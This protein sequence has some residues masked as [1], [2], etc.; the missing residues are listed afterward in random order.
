METY[1]LAHHGVTG[2]KWGVMHG[3]PYPLARTSDGRLNT[4]A[5]A[6]AKRRYG[7]IQQVTVADIKKQEKKM[8]LRTLLEERRKKKK[9]ERAAREAIREK[10]AA[11]RKAE[12]EA[13]EAA[14]R[15]MADEKLKKA[16][17]DK[18]A[19]LKQY[20]RNHPR[21]LAKYTD[22]FTNEELEEIVSQ[23]R[24][25]RKVKDVRDEEYRRYQRYADDA[26]SALKTVSAMAE[27]SI[28]IYNSTASIWNAIGK[29]KYDRKIFERD[30]AEAKKAKD[31]VEPFR[32]L[33]RVGGNN[34]Q[35]GDK[36]KQNQ[37]NNNNQ[38]NQN[39]Q[40]QNNQGDQQKK[41]KK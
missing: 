32:P 19:A 23:I 8:A 33:P 6:K 15:K 20:V 18:Q 25:D 17:Q 9:D 3:P 35:N 22:L 40:N 2:M 21:E 24:L 29:E 37:Q 39:N 38:N 16:E 10:E 11:E 5:Q 1:Y 14:R 12:R 27:T 41:K 7:T 26:L 30:N 31:Y 28:A 4:K 34:N 36:N 13:A